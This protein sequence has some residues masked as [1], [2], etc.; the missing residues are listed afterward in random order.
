MESIDLNKIPVQ[1]TEGHTSKGN[2]LKWKLGDQWYKADHMGYEGLSEVLVS[3]LLHKTE[4]KY[5]FVEYHPVEI[6]YKGQK[7]LGCRSNNFLK[8]NQKLIPLEKLYRQNTGRSLALSLVEF[9]EVP[10]RIRYTVE[11]VEKYTGLHDFGKYLTAMLELDAFF[12]N[13]DRHTNNIAVLYDTEKDCYELSPIFD[14]GLSL[15]ADTSFDFSLEQPLED[16][17]KRVEAKP[18]HSSFVQ[19]VD[20][21]RT[22]WYPNSLQFR[23]ERSAERTPNVKRGLFG[24][25][26]YAGRAPSSGTDA[27]ICIPDGLNRKR[28][29]WK[30]KQK[31]MAAYGMRKILLIHERP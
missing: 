7:L 14:Q 17:I 30:Y 1:E 10:N 2:Q 4:L 5:P 3:R 13:E 28:I 22:V 26:H 29:R 24:G 31:R 25:D 9:P 15:L 20:A 18:F 12:L 11:Q 19:Q 6:A 27:P 23:S 21:G 8:E 16:C